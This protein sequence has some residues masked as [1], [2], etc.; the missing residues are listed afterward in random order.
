MV[1]EVN[2]VA[3]A[4]EQVS[5]NGFDLSCQSRVRIDDDA[6]A[7]Y[8]AVLAEGGELPAA[9][10]FRDVDGRL[11]LSSGHHRRLAYERAGR[12][13]MPVV[14]RP[15]ARWEA[16]AHGIRANAQHGVRLT[17]EDRRHNVELIL[18]ERPDMS[19]R[20]V[21]DLAGVHYNTV[22]K[23]RAELVAAA[24]ITNCDSRTGRDGRAISTAKIGERR[25]GATVQVGQSDSASAPS[26]GAESA[27]AEERRLEMTSEIPESTAA[28][29]VVEV[30]VPQ[31]GPVSVTVQPRQFSDLPADLQNWAARLKPEELAVFWRF[32]RIRRASGESENGIGWRALADARRALGQWSAK[33]L[34]VTPPGPSRE[35]RRTETASDAVVVGDEPKVTSEATGPRDGQAGLGGPN[36]SKVKAAVACGFEHLGRCKKSLDDLN[37]IFPSQ[38]YRECVDALDAVEQHLTAWWTEAKTGCDSA[39]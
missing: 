9:E 23:V 28:E 36:E 32:L 35:P 24:S 25:G 11:Y 29:E 30:S 18:R 8:A 31:S 27:A 34:S 15:G 10:A 6:V 17:R 13:T 16:L 12:E 5:V 22:S 1:A 37:A 20:A 3:E 4:V 39:S 38:R 14:V 7:D 19:D 21:A 33:P 2:G 26:E